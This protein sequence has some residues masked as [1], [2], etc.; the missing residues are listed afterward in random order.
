[1]FFCYICVFFC[2]IYYT[3]ISVLLLYLFLSIFLFDAV[4][5]NYFY[6][7][8]S[9]WLLITST[10]KYNWLLYSDFVFW[11]KMKVLVAQPCPTLCDLMDCSPPGSSALGILQARVLGLVAIPFSRGS[12]RPRDRTHV[13]HISGKFFT[14][15]ATREAET[16]LMNLL[17]LVAFMR[18]SSYFLLKVYIT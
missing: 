14:I 11:R 7:Y 15:W 3:Y 17:V 13:S 10:W 5:N 18:I 2:Y 6:L 16:L 12:S 4:V 9:I 1:M 8:F